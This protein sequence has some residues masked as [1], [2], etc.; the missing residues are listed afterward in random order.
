L[1]PPNAGRVGRQQQAQTGFAYRSIKKGHCI[2]PAIAFVFGLLFKQFR[3][4]P[5]VGFLIAGFVL[6]FLGAEND[7]FLMELADLGVTLLLF[8]IGLKLRLSTMIRPEIW[9][10][11][12]VHMAGSIFLSVALLLGLG[13]SNIAIFGELDITGILIVAFAL[14]FSSTVFA[15]KTLEDRGTL[16][17][18]YGQV[19][20][21]VLVKRDGLTNICHMDAATIIYNNIIDYRVHRLKITCLKNTEP[22][23]A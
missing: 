9:A 14:S 11:T 15:V 13:L 10:T 19:A 3:L 17:S 8:T 7:Q 16:V 21:G 1:F 22:I 23:A 20:I 6:H 12:T 18:R 2:T 5:M 4:P